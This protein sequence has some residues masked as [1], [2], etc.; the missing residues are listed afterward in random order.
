MWVKVTWACKSVQMKAAGELCWTKIGVHFKTNLHTEWEDT[1]SLQQQFERHGEIKKTV[2][3]KIQFPS[4]NPGSLCSVVSCYLPNIFYYLPWICGCINTL[5]QCNLLW[6]VIFIYLFEQNHTQCVWGYQL[7]KTL[8][9][10]QKSMFELNEWTLK[11]W[12]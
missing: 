5:I 4:S 1:I 6:L 11:L 8:C 9:E 7:A 3:Y 10:F 2:Q 12:Y